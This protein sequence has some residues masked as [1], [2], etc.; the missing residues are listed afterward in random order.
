VVDFAHSLGRINFEIY[1]LLASVF[2]RMQDFRAVLYELAE[3]KPIQLFINNK[4][5]PTFLC[6]SS[7]CLGNSQQTRP[8]QTCT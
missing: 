5:C 2:Q 4:V 1:V 6:L 8:L 7:H 3:I